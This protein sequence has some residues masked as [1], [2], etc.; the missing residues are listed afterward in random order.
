MMG[1]DHAISNDAVASISLGAAK[2][3][4]PPVAD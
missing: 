1:Y 3:A 2:P 4:K